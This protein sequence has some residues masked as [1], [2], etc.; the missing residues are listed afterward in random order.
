M[1][2]KVLLVLMSLVLIVGGVI[3]GWLWSMYEPFPGEARISA[4]NQEYSP[5]NEARIEA[6][7]RMLF[8][9]RAR[10]NLP[11]ISLAIGL[12]GEVVYQTAVGFV[13]L[14]EETQ[15]HPW[16]LYR[17]GSVSKPITAV[18]LAQMAEEG[19]IDMDLPFREYVPDFPQKQ[20]SFTPRQLASHTA[21]VRH[22]N[23]PMESYISDHFETVNDALVL[24]ENDRLLFE[25]GTAFRYSS[26]GYNMLSAAMVAADG[27]PFAEMLQARIFDPLEMN[28]IQVEDARW[29]NP[30]TVA[31]YY[32]VGKRS[33]EAFYA[34][35]SYKVAGGGLIGTPADLVKFGNALLAGEL[36]R[37]DTWQQ[38]IAPVPLSDGSTNHNYGL[39]FGS[40][41]VQIGERSVR[42][43]GH[44]GGSVGGL[45]AWK[46]FPGVN[47]AHGTHDLVVA[48]TMNISNMGSDANPHEV[49]YLAAEQVL[50]GLDSGEIVSAPL[51]GYQAGPGDW[52]S[53]FD[54]ET[55]DGWTPKVRGYPVGENPLDTFRVEEGNLV[56][57]YDDYELFEERFGHLFYRTPYSHYR[58]QLEYRF[59]GEPTPGT[60]EW[61]IRNSGVML[62]AQAPESMPAE[63]DFPI[64]IEFQF[65]GGYEG[66]P[67]R[68]TGNLCTPGTHV[69]LEGEFTLTHCI[70][71]NSAMPMG[72]H[73]ISA[74]A[75]VLGDREIT[76]YI[77]GAP[78][79][80]YNDPVTG[81][82]MVF[83]HDPAMKPE[84]APL[85]SGYIA[86][87]S[88]GHRVEFRNIRLLNL[89]GCMNPHASNYRAWYVEDDP[90]ACAY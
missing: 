50:D 28:L 78:V 30:N 32:Q 71:A 35:N 42:E 63:Q 85:G 86:L 75:L 13:D 5:L 53:L 14:D 61:A 57:S 66:G 40:G 34:D 45:T 67:Y 7:D 69:T 11:S 83:G 88:E 90:V 58:L 80:R 33:L 43:I 79:L 12:D 22:Y 15:A 2:K 73:W 37:A 65:L 31:F 55:L 87:Q 46:L 19:L 76:H 29:P 3:A 6:L 49:A 27:R 59:V 54:G 89:K 64:S 62:H 47:T 25:P 82:G 39:G 74:E 23:S 18:A 41:E 44:S 51:P 77:D 52:V 48:V 60:P 36:I 81:G 10:D 9:Q 56:V 4:R 24:V 20:W 84:D 1:W 38:L 17:I 26:Y 68:V 72:D 16:S 70:T 21:G 8:A